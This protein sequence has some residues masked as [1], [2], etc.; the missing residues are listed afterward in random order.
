MEHLL[1]D[2]FVMVTTGCIYQP[3]LPPAASTYLR[4]KIN[5][6]PNYTTCDSTSDWHECTLDNSFFF[7]HD[8]ILCSE[9][10]KKTPSR[11]ES[12]LGF[13]YLLDTNIYKHPKTPN[14]QDLPEESVNL[15]KVST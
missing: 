2:L 12:L 5:K 7:P 4:S 1:Q 10:H 6:H 15:R 9:I 8:E 14:L 11:S 3:K 13:C